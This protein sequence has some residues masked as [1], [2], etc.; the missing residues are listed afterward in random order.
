M[1]IPAWL[2]PASVV[3]ILSG[4]ALGMI[5]HQS[6]AQIFETL[7]SWLEPVG[8]AWV[9]ALL[10]I[11]I[12]L[13][14]SVLI[15]AVAET[16]KRTLAGIGGLTVGLF[17]GYALLAGIFTLALGPWVVDALPLSESL[18]A[19]A[20]AAA[21]EAGS[22]IDVVTED[23]P[24]LGPWLVGLIPANAVRAAVEGDLVGIV[25]ASAI[26]GLALNVIG[27]EGRTVVAF[28]RGVRSVTL[29]V[30]RWVLLLIPLGAFALSYSAGKASG[31]AM[32]GAIGIWIVTVSG[33][34]AGFLAVIYLVTWLVG[35]CSLRSFSRAVLPAQGVAVSTRSS[36]ASLP[37]LFQS[38]DA[39]GI[40]TSVSSVSLSLAG[41]M[42]RPNTVISSTLSLIFLARVYGLEVAFPYLV[43]FTL[44]RILMSF[45][46]PGIPSGMVMLMLPFFVAAGVPVEGYILIRVVDAIPDLLKTVLNV[47]AALSVCL[48]TFTLADRWGIPIS[49]WEGERTGVPA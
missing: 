40:P 8:R 24:G 7:G 39:L 4:F 46:E 11:L 36:L 12:P 33:M 25:I 20:R 38:A 37:A 27:S 22:A 45:A 19:T 48:L 41:S 21:V 44:V 15:V 42:F 10:M 32:A 14:V 31:L 1:A 43:F 47:T 13:I 17:L 34:L 9:N 28:V 16:P 2:T 18:A 26:F 49:G 23:F 30:T 5:A 3:G 29:V 35:K 6:G